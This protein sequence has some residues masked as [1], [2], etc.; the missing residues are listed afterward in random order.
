MSNLR[1]I[2]DLLTLLQL[3]H[4]LFKLRSF[5][6]LA[7]VPKPFVGLV[8]RQPDGISQLLYILRFQV[9]FNVFAKEFL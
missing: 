2:K 9:L 7:V 8:L 5:L 3:L 4:N 6:L 1:Y